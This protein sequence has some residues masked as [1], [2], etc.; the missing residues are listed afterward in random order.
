MQ[1]LLLVMVVVER[2]HVGRLHR[3][4]LLL[5][6]QVRRGV[7][8]VLL[9]QELL[10]MVVLTVQVIHLHAGRRRRQ[11]FV[12]GIV[13]VVAGGFANRMLGMLHLLGHEFRQSGD[14][15]QVL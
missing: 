5:L 3:M 12:E 13:H 11:R 7:T 4:S 9:L 2:A 8:L 1:M 14:V 15:F 6:L 10:V